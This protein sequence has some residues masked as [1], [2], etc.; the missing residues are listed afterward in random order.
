MLM[1]CTILAILGQKI[2]L[3]YHFL[4]YLVVFQGESCYYYCI[5][6][7]AFMHLCQITNMKMYNLTNQTYSR[8]L[9]CIHVITNAIVNIFCIHDR[10]PENN[11]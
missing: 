6:L 1:H 7:L 9:I 10:Q 4:R 3:S 5:N 11:L 8:Q 2:V